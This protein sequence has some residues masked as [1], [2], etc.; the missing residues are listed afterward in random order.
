MLR[1]HVEKLSDARLTCV[2]IDHPS[3]ESEIELTHSY[4]YHSQE[5]KKA[6]DV[7]IRR[8]LA[9]LREKGFVVSRRRTF[10]G[11][12]FGTQYDYWT[13]R[14]KDDYHFKSLQDASKKADET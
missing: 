11:I 12:G 14:L 5:E 4:P 10:S 6:H 3:R 2:S 13:I 1:Q 7:H 8:F 9:S